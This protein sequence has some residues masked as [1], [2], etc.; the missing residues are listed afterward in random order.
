M[1]CRTRAEVLEVRSVLDQLGG[2]Y[3]ERLGKCAYG[4]H[5]RAVYFGALQAPDMVPMRADHE[6][7]HRP[8]FVAAILHD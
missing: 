5:A 3:L 7:H 4:A 2:L 6:G 8:L 1:W